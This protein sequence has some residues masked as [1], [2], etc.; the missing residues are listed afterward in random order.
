MPRGGARKGAGRRST[1]TSGCTREDT[2]PIR[3]PK[4]LKDKINDYA[5]KLDAGE[6]LECVVK[7]LKEENEILKQQLEEGRSS[8]NQLS[9]FEADKKDLN[10]LRDDSLKLLK[11]GQQSQTYKKCKKAFDHFIASLNR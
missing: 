6:D 10:K 2:I 4:I 5:H 1:W 9:L 3:V 7:S 11:M 8:S